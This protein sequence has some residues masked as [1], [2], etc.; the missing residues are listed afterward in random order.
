ML[1]PLFCDHRLQPEGRGSLRGPPSPA[2]PPSAWAVCPPLGY[3]LSRVPRVGPG[4][5]KLASALTRTLPGAWAVWR[6]LSLTVDLWRVVNLKACSFCLFLRE[7]KENSNSF[8]AGHRRRSLQQFWPLMTAASLSSHLFPLSS[9]SVSSA[10][11]STFS[12][13]R[14]FSLLLKSLKIYLIW[15]SG[16]KF[17]AYVGWRSN[18]RISNIRQG[19]IKRGDRAPTQAAPAPCPA[20]APGGIR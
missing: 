18:F 2:R 15:H 19:I 14:I 11:F 16:G 20:R 4:R 9:R 1:R 10:L 7:K 3:P 5:L 17:K 6:D 13:E 8:W 12:Y